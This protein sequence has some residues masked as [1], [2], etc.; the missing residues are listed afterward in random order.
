MMRSRNPLAKTILLVAFCT[1]GAVSVRAAEDEGPQPPQSPQA[2]LLADVGID[3]RLNESLPLGLEFRDEQ[4]RPVKL[5][6]YFGERPVVLALVYYQCPQLCNQ[7]LNGLFTALKSLDFDAGRDY[8][9][10]VVSFEPKEDAE[11][12]RSKKAAYLHR[13]NREG[14]EHGIHFLTGEQPEIDALTKAAGFRYEFDERSGQ[15]AHA[16]GIMVSTP[17]G[18]LARYFY[19][20]DY[21][22]RDLR[23]GLVEASAGKIGSPVDAILLY[24]FHYDP[25]TGKYG[26]AIRRVLQAAGALTVLGLGTAIVVMLR[27]ERKGRQRLARQSAPLP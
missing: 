16:S 7:V 26:L 23:L 13:L 20:I 18:K 19:G 12:A 6:H 14:A 25:L 4:N 22:P 15:Y 3:Q 1:F 21:P 11:L 24:C 27:W 10:V 2:A 17:Q 8:E 5:A 9:V